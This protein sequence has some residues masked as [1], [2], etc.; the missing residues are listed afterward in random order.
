MRLCI[1]YPKLDEN[2]LR[3][4]IP[5]A[6]SL[7]MAPNSRLSRLCLWGLGKRPGHRT[8][9]GARFCD[10]GQ[11]AQDFTLGRKFFQTPMPFYLFLLTDSA[12]RHSRWRRSLS[13]S[14]PRAYREITSYYQ[15]KVYSPPPPDPLSKS[16]VWPLGRLTMLGLFR[17]LHF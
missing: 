1:E 15:Y 5:P 12:R 9:R 16:M 10:T 2:F 13:T 14:S 7:P 17:N 8:G 11:D 6:Q 3:S 4:T